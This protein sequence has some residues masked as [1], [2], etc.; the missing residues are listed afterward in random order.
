MVKLKYIAG[1]AGALSL[2]LLLVGGCARDRGDERSGSA[3][4]PTAS[5]PVPIDGSTVNPGT[6]PGTPGIPPPA[7]TTGPDS[8]GGYQD[9]G[10]PQPTPS[11]PANITAPKVP[12]RIGWTTAT[13]TS[14]GSG[15]CYKLK[16]SD[17]ETWAVYSKKSIPM[18]EGDKVRARIT[19][20]KTAVSCGTGKPG[21][22]VRVLIDPR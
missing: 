13:V 11:R 21:T 22:L 7:S 19:P 6:D 4:L 17:G 18:G 3:S 1:T 12:P 2:A 5:A 14:G 15:P 20:G 10:A 16:S 8:G 9:P